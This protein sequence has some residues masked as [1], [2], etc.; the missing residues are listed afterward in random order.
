MYTFQNGIILRY[1]S[2]LLTLSENPNS[3]IFMNS[4][5]KLFVVLNS[6]PVSKVAMQLSSFH[7]LRVPSKLEEYKKSFYSS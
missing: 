3:S 4:P 2:L 1:L 6:W 5:K 7:I